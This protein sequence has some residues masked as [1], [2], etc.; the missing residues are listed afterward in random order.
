M[1]A[2]EIDRYLREAVENVKE[3]LRWWFQNRQVYP[4]LSRMALDYLSTPP[5]STAVERV[6][7]RGRQLLPFT[8]SGLSAASIR[9]QLCLGSWCRCDLIRVEEIQ[10]A[11]T[12]K[13]RKHVSSGTEAM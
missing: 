13:K 7:S 6:F 10:A 1:V 5:T 12:G 11:I 2:N 3:P 9:T 4:K 8:R